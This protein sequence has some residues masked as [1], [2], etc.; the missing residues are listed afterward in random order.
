MAPTQKNALLLEFLML[1]LTRRFHSSNHPVGLSSAR[2]NPSRPPGLCLRNFNLC[3]HC[4]AHERL[5]L[6]EGPN[7]WGPIV[8]RSDGVNFHLVLGDRPIAYPTKHATAKTEAMS[9]GFWYVHEANG[10]SNEV[11]V[12]ILRRPPR[13]GASLLHHLEAVA[14]KLF[15]KLRDSSRLACL[16][17]FNGDRLREVP[18]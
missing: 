4:L 3:P 6:V 14:D 13:D 15:D 8:S 1:T 2:N 7:E 10:E 16:Y 18:H 17:E 5:V 9:V 12:V 11:V